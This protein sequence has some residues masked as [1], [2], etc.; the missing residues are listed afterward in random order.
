MIFSE[1]EIQA[2]AYALLQQ[3]YGKVYVRGEYKKGKCRFDLV[4]LNKAKEIVIVIEC[5]KD[6]KKV[7]D[8]QR[9]QYIEYTGVKELITCNEMWQAEAIL[10]I[11][12]YHIKKHNIIF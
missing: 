2:V 10:D 12:D 1:F 6:G 7:K 9:N 5:K 3:K 8:K 4:I 11:V